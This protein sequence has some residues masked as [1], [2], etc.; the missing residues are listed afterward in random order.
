MIPAKREKLF[1]A[2]GAPFDISGCHNFGAPLDKLE[3]LG[4]NAKC[5]T[6]EAGE[7]GTRSEPLGALRKRA[8][9]KYYSGHL[10]INLAQLNSPLKRSYLVTHFQCAATLEQKDTKVTAR[11]CG[12]RW[13]VVCNRIRTAQLLN[14]YAAPLAALSEK[15]FVTLT[16][17]NVPGA[18]L[19]ATL[20]QMTKTMQAIQDKFKKRHR[21]GLQPWQLVGLRKLECTYN[22]KAGNYHPHLHFVISGAEAAKAL[23][24][25]WLERTPTATDK[26]QDMREAKDGTANELFKY[27]AKLVTKQDGKNITLTEPLDTIFQAMRGLR[28]FQPIGIKKDVPEEIEN[29]QSVEVEGITPAP[30]HRYFEWVEGG[31]DWVNSETGEALTGY[32]PSPQ[33]DELIENIQSINGDKTAIRPAPRTGALP[34]PSHP[35]P[36]TGALPASVVIDRN[37]DR[38]IEG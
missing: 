22:A 23:I 30:E 27:F 12:H 10:A 36:W 19:R 38:W 26:A 33:M 31:S 20:C 3:Q 25:E 1:V 2:P 9:A 13:C 18:E 17:P 21:R 6:N 37:L 15:Y 11:Y 29:L 7:A 24:A 4:T 35:A 8:R 14:G 34:A 32:L 5:A 28:V 16:L